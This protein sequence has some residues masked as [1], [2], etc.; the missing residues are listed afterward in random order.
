M[1]MIQREERRRTGD[2]GGGVH[3]G[4]VLALAGP[5]VG[6]ADWAVEDVL[7][8]ATSLGKCS[9]G[10]GSRCAYFRLLDLEI[11]LHTSSLRS[12]SKR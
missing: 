7:G 8:V 2:V 10:F 9:A 4:V 1:I 11:A 6:V 12:D 3:A 5:A